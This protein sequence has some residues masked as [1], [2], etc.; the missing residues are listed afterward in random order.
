LRLT[1]SPSSYTWNFVDVAG[2]TLD[3][4]ADVCH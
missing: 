1:L 4:G 3:A 2:M